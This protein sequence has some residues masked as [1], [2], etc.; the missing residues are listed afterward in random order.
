MKTILAF[1]DFVL[2][3]SEGTKRKFK[4]PEW[5]EELAFFDP[6]VPRNIWPQSVVPAPQGGY[7]LVYSG[8]PDPDE[9]AG[10]AN[11]SVFLAWSPDGMRFEPYRQ[12][13]PKARY[14]HMI[15]RMRDGVG[16]YAII[17]R[18]EQDP[19]FRYKS[20]QASYDTCGDSVTEGPAYLLGSPDM[21][22]WKRVNGAP[23]TPSYIDCF[24]GLLRNPR[25]GRLQA[26][27]RRRWGERRICLVES[28]DTESWTFPRA[29]VHPGPYDEPVT[30]LYSMPEFY[31]EPGEIFIGLLWKHVMPFDRVM[32]GVVTTEYAYSYDGLMWN[33][34]N[35]P[36][37]PE[38]E[39]GEYG[40]GSSACFSMADRGDDVVFYMC[41]QLYEHSGAPGSVRDSRC[42]DTVI[43]GTLKRN[44]FVSIDSGKGR[45]EL[46]TQW[47]RL[48]K[49]ELNLNAV[50]PYGSLRAELRAG[51]SAVEGYAL[52]DFM[53][54]YGD[55]TDAPMHW[56]GGGLERFVEEG[57]WLQLHIVFEQSEVFAVTGDLDFNINTLAP[58]YEHL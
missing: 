34:T 39:R 4:Q 51:G 23:V 5:H 10:E 12:V 48:K 8:F 20:P 41:A 36:L 21:I 14:P 17:D 30:H 57:E 58:A 6:A 31:Y 44:R 40:S 54:V 25:T 47:L 3:R 32:D 43:P 7:Y 11:M 53:P 16:T 56:K 35:A 18:E 26:T 13:D 38:K 46:V 24:P 55:V 1:D 52:D 45:G 9:P 27:T 28:S 29:V 22:H 37:Y 50:I 42:G 15:G 49:P 33:R 19:E 2:N